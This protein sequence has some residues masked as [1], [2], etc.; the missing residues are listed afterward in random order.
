MEVSCSCK[1][2][3]VLDDCGD[4]GRRGVIRGGGGGRD[5][6]SRYVCSC[7]PINYHRVLTA[8]AGTLRTYLGKTISA[9]GNWVSPRNTECQVSVYPRSY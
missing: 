1:L 4:P 3:I 7:P 5:W 2:T 8:L 6:R 9:S